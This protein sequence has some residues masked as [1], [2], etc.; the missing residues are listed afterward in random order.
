M[1]GMDVEVTQLPPPPPLSIEDS[2]VGGRG[3]PVDGMWMGNATTHGEEY[4]EG[5]F[6]AMK[7]WHAGPTLSTT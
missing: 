5:G 3:W 6:V 4:Y 1:S 2:E 7:I